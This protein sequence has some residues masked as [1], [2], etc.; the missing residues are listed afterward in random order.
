[1]TTRL[2]AGT[3]P[4]GSRS[5]SAAMMIRRLADIV[6]T[7]RV[8]S[9]ERQVLSE[10]DDRMLRDIGVTRAEVYREATKPFWRA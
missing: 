3:R 8:R 10:L 7:W 6:L 5:G 4:F 1:M 9:R 2:A